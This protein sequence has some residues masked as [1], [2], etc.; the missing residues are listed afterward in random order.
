MRCDHARRVLVA[1]PCPST[2]CPSCRRSDTAARKR[3]RVWAV[4]WRISSMGPSRIRLEPANG[5]G[6][7][8]IRAPRRQNGNNFRSCSNGSP[9]VTTEPDADMSMIS[10]RTRG[11]PRKSRHPSHFHRAR[12]PE[13]PGLCHQGCSTTKPVGAANG[14]PARRLRDRVRYALIIRTFRRPPPTG[15][16]GQIG[17]A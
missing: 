7:D 5:T 13:E 1:C 17:E 8:E 6:L 11:K 9:G 15:A 12:G 4:V 10:A 14:G 2:T 3:C 16:Q